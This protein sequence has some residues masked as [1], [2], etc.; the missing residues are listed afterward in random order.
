M[1]RIFLWVLPLLAFAACE[2]DDTEVK[3]RLDDLG[4]KVAELE[5]QVKALNADLTTL[6][7]LIAGKQ[8]ISDVKDNGDGSYTLTLVTAAGGSTSVTI[9]DGKDA[10]APQIG[11]KLDTDGKYYWTLDGVFITDGGGGKLPVSGENGVTPQFKIDEGYW[12]VSYDGEA[13]WTR[14]GKATGEDGT[15][16]FKSVTVSEDGTKVYITLQDD[17]VLTF[18]LYV[19]FGIAFDTAT[20]ALR[21]GGS[22]SVPFSLTGADAKTVIEALP[23]AGW[24]AEV[25]HT[26]GADTG[27]IEV[28]A[29]ADSSTGKVVVLVN[30]GGYKTLMRTLTFVAGVLNVSTSSGEATAAGGTVT[31]EVETDLDYTVVIPDNAKSWITL[32]ETRADVRQETLTFIVEANTLPE[33]REATVEL[34][35][36]GSVIETVLI[37]QLAYYNPEAMVLKV[38]A[39]AYTS[40]NAKYT[41]MVYLPL[42][43]AVNAT[44]D[45]GD[46]NTQTV[47]STI[48]TAA[49]MANHTYDKDGFYYVTITGN[50]AQLTGNLIPTALQSAIVNVIQW[51]KLGFGS[52]IRAFSGNKSLKTVPSP[53]PDAFAAVSTAESMFTGCS[54]LEAVPAD[55][56]AGASELTSVASLFYNCAALESVPGNL[57]EK[58]TKITTAGSLFSGCAKLTAVPEELFRTT[59]EIKTLSSL[60]AK[61]SAL[62]SVPEKLFAS[63]TEA[64]NM[65]SLFTECASLQTVPADLFKNQS[66]VKNIAT[67]FKGCKALE[68]VPE[69]L[70]DAFTEATNMNS[71]FSTCTRLGNLPTDIFRNLTNVTSAGY[72]Y[73]GCVS[74]TEFPSIK[75]CVKLKTVN[76]LWKDCSTL[77]SAPADYFPD[78]EEI[79]KGTTAAYMFQNCSALKNV[80]EG[81]FDNLT[82]VTIISQMFE[83]CTSLE[84]L[85]AGL[86]DKMTAIKTASKTFNGCTAFTGESPYTLIEGN[87][88]HLYDRAPANGFTAITSFADCFKN[89]ANIADLNLIPIAWGGKNDGTKAKPTLTLALTPIDGAEYYGMNISIKGTELKS[90]RYGLFTKARAEEFYKEMGD[91]WEKVCNRNCTGIP[92]SW[93]TDIHSQDGFQGEIKTLEA[94]T[95]YMLLVSGTNIHGTTVEQ[96]IARTAPYPTGNTAYE[97]YVGTWTV[98]STSSEISQ[99]PLTFDITIEPYR[100][101]ESFRVY[102]WGIST[103][104]AQM[105]APFLL[106]YAADGT[107]AVSTEDYIAGLGDGFYLYLKYRFHNPAIPGYSIWTTGNVLMTGTFSN[108]GESFTLAGKEFTDPSNDTQYTVCG[109]DYFLYNSGNWYEN[110]YYTKP[111]YT[112]GDYAIG[113][114]TLTRATAPAKASA[115]RN[116]RT[117]TI[118]PIGDKAT[119]QVPT[120]AAQVKKLK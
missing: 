34:V 19:E 101:D 106:Q 2:Y 41:N 68:S 88:I 70:L 113:P 43:G 115:A 118:E 60:F 16:F 31:A 49:A 66:K 13:T 14:L 3:N 81:M 119:V 74:M 95:E 51:G 24:S 79:R 62:E 20:G 26:E 86:F 107:V 85:P 38:E 99:K 6:G 114:Y 58:N 44:I 94:D 97:R 104:S 10:V 63:L 11:V 116:D 25:K 47:E 5:Q 42:Y 50:A 22:I 39:K 18:D 29:P 67:M 80:P 23:A 35:C 59:P 96:Y 83:N 55:L 120:G 65:A 102:D 7:D 21:V 90:G 87:K 92:A 36:N 111:G 110:A 52:L 56:L 46:G 12:Y 93:L 33:P 108:E 109:M 45:W 98:T 8:F 71:L 103:Y 78:S 28:T 100:I 9:R 89:C 30:D 82:G 112:T 105:N 17:T 15:A 40:T 1:K 91:N 76:A 27:T 69:G 37:Y 32:A 117:L 64:D 4:G 57:F 73:E 48:S 61:C 54:A 75:N 72:L 53:E 77:V 84:T